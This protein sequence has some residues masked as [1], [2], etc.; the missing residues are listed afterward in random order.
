MKLISD[1]ISAVKA[2]QAE[3]AASLVEGNCVNFETY[4]RLVGQHQGLQ[5]SLDALNNLMKEK[6]EHE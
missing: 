3:I 5:A 2:H 6:D 1:F 4:Q